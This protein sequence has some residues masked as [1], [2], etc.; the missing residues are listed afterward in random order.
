MKIASSTHQVF[1]RW[2]RKDDDEWTRA[3]YTRSSMVKYKKEQKILLVYLCSISF[4]SHVPKKENIH[5]FLSSRCH[6]SRGDWLNNTFPTPPYPKGVWQWV[7]LAESKDG[8]SGSCQ[9]NAVRSETASFAS[10]LLSRSTILKEK[11]GFFFGEEIV[12]MV[13]THPRMIAAVVTRFARFLCW[14]SS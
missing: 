11:K 2:S 4:Y 6:E 13:Q 1:M 12:A 3:M 10:F 5:Q 14:L 8:D 9:S 7:G